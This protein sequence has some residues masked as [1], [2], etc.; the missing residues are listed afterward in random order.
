MP[1]AGRRRATGGRQPA[2]GGGEHEA[3][4][5][6]HGRGENWMPHHDVIPKIPIA[7]AR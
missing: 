4:C 7:M 2:N 5:D 3:G 6:Q 1:A